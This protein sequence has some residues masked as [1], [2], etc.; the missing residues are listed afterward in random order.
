MIRYLLTKTRPTAMIAIL[1]LALISAFGSLP[2]PVEAATGGELVDNPEFNNGTSAWRTNSNTQRLEVVP[3]GNGHIARLTTPVSQSVA[4]NDATNTV[5]NA[6]AP[7]K[8]YVVE[9]RVRTATPPVNGAVRVREVTGGSVV[10]H[11]SSFSLQDDRW[12][13][14]RLNLTTNLRNASLDLNVLAW[15]LDAK[16]QLQIDSI[17]MRQSETTPPPS[18][19]SPP[20]ST[21][22]PRHLPGDTLFGANISTVGQSFE[23]S[24]S[25]LDSTFTKNPVL[26]IFDQNRPKAWSNSRNSLIKDRTVVIS[27]NPSPQ[28]VLSGQHDAYL[29]NWF[30]S[31][32]ANQ[33]IFWSYIHEPETKIKAGQF[34]AAQYRSAW[35][36]ID[37]IADEQCH[38]NMIPTLILT[39][40]TS[41][42]ASGRSYQTFDPGH[43]VVE[44]IAWDPYNGIHV[45]RDYYE[46]PSSM[47]GEILDIHEA[48][49][50][51]WAIAETGARLIKGDKGPGRAQWLKDVGA[52]LKQNGA[53]F[54]TYYY[55]HGDSQWRLDDAP[56]RKAWS[57]L[58]AGSRD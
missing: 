56:S 16:S 25:E 13:P 51:P 45:D 49:G 39:S 36:H 54:G 57:G 42:P 2:R 8:S 28:S 50:R 14:V 1:S 58:V 35:K 24:L 4:L 44:V 5:E 43:D 10:T 47:M 41:K 18:N 20:P 11:Q 17:S 53:L 7:G 46:A 21:E 19:P 22:C 12:T 38:P 52:Y 15:N 6:G 33:T 27:F 30:A 26:R 3:G 37:Q 48:D 23:E 9:A 29:R 55:S 31:A 40:W 32:P 34:T